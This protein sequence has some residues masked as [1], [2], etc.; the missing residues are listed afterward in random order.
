M[1]PSIIAVSDLQVHCQQG[2]GKPDRLIV[3]ASE[4][5]FKLAGD[6]QLLSVDYARGKFLAPISHCLRRRS[7]HDFLGVKP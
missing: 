6:K 4:C 1:T 2:F 7:A 3:M 5:S